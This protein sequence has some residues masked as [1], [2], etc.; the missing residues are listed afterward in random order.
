MNNRVVFGSRTSAGNLWNFAGWNRELYKG[1]RA[2]YIMKNVTQ[3]CV[4]FGLLCLLF[5]LCSAS[6][7]RSAPTSTGATLAGHVEAPGHVPAP[8]ARVALIDV[9]TRQRKL[10]WTD[11]TGAYRFTNVSPGMYVLFVSL[12]GFRPNIIRPF[13]VQGGGKQNMDVSLQLALPGEQPR[14]AGAWRRNPAAGGMPTGGKGLP[15]AV[16]TGGIAGMGALENSGGSSN[17]NAGLRFSQ[18]AAAGA[19]TG[20]ETTGNP[21]LQLSASADNSF[22]LTGNVVK[23]PA[24]SRLNWKDRRMMMRSQQ[25]GQTAPGFGGQNGHYENMI[26]FFGAGHRP[27]VNR[28]RGMMFDTYTNSALDARPYPLNVPESPQIPSYSERAG[29]S[30]GGPLVIPKIYNGL[31]KTSFFV[32]YMLVRSK[33]PFD[34]FATVPTAAERLGDFSNTVIP[35]GPLAGTTPTIYQPFTGTPFPGNQIPE[36]SFSPAAKALLAY[37]PLPNLPGQVQNFHLQESLPAAQ[38]VIMGRIGQQ[39][40]GKD[41][42]SVF[43]FLSSLRTNSVSSFPELTS[44]TSTLGQNLNVLESHTLDPHTVNILTVNFN[45]QRIS[46]LNPFAFTQNIAGDLGIQG[47]SQNPMDWGIP[48][49]NFT[50][51]TSLNDTIPSLTRNQT[52]RFSDFAIVTRGNH[53]LHLGGEIRFIQVNTLTDPGARGSFTFSGY[54]TSAFSSQGVPVNGTGFDFADFLL[55]LPQTT[56]ARFGSSANYLRSRAYDAFADD[57]WRFN[58]HFTFDLGLRYEYFAPFTEKYGHLSDLALGQDYSTVGVVTA[59]NP[60]NLPAS[61]LHGQTNNWSPRIGIAY[62]PW[63]NHSLVVRAGYSIF[64]DGAIYQQLAPNLVD[65]PPFATASTLLTNPIQLLT[66]ENGFPTTG[67]SVVR[68]TYAVDPN[69]L[70]PYAQTWD[71]MLEQP[72]AANTILSL[73]Y[74]GTRGTHLD[75]LLAPNLAATGSPA[76]GQ[77][78]LLLQNAQPFIYDTSGASSIYHGL[79]V[80][81]RRLFHGGLAFYADYTYSK[82]MDDAASVG[83]AGTTV[84]QNPFNLQEEWGLS[85]FNQTHQFLIGYHYQLPF[86]DHRHFLNHGGKLARIFSGWEVSGFTTVESGTPYTAFV[87]GNLSN[88]VNGAAPFGSLRANVTGLPVSLPGSA[89][90]TLDFFNTAAFTLPAPGQYGNAGRDTIPGPG[91]VNFDTSIDRLLTISREKGINAD[92]RLSANNLFNTANFTGLATTVNA[93]D[94]GRVTSVGSMRTL[95]LTMRLRF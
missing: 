55:G 53:N 2:N 40:S 51:F 39:F 79:R 18:G 93:A 6:A 83:G 36:T 47:V 70:T 67:P 13:A 91:L 89:Q 84:A 65:Q 21:S 73:A 34:S 37:I 27:H 26:F 48:L 30:L 80:G 95:S 12:I 94:F 59:Q 1:D 33:S 4:S 75:L 46:V 81:L 87:L 35:S 14:M 61:L 86:G 57:D 17:G 43:Y 66:L 16:G 29:I 15:M 68:N 9:R 25:S 56:S 69:F 31:N 77:G 28:L 38:D 60:G 50:N 74:V 22:L 20:G 11:E 5:L 76:A 8:S 10:T 88:N 49:I 90:T 54:T 24:P 64:Y 52:L 19:E 92:V 42:L 23:V 72:L 82:A 7:A 85:S 3:P 63:V 78:G 32:H 44:H 45:R 62:R 71:L 58:Q 41:N